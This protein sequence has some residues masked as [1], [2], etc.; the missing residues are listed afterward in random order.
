MALGYR[1]DAKFSISVDDLILNSSRISGFY[2]YLVVE[3]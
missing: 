3:I 2:L 1:F